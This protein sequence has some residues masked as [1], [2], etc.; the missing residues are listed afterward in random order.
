MVSTCG[1][2]TK[3]P[4]PPCQTDKA[5]S[6]ASLHSF[7]SILGE[8]ETSSHNS[9]AYI[10]FFFFFQ[11]DF[12]IRAT[13]PLLPACTCIDLCCMDF[14]CDVLKLNQSISLNLSRLATSYTHMSR[15][16]RAGVFFV[17]FFWLAHPPV[18]LIRD[19]FSKNLFI[20][21]QRFI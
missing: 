10:K 5:T 2:K 6:N 15:F 21:R 9:K 13:R 18:N 8:L 3:Q 12:E 17:F 16:A 11:I 1:T 19:N 4:L 7:V 20:S 14:V